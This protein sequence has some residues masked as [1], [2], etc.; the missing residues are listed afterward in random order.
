[1]NLS[2]ARA[3]GII[4][5]RLPI[6]KETMREN[7]AWSFTPMEIDFSISRDSFVSCLLNSVWDSG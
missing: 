1:M 2:T 4:S 3:P 5:C 7:P 6:A